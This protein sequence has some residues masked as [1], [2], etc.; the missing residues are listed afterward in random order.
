MRVGA[1]LS[2][3]R[4]GAPEN[5][6]YR[7]DNDLLPVSHP[8]STR[9]V[10]AAAV[11]DYAEELA[12]SLLGEDG[13]ASTEDAIFAL[14]EFSGLGYEAEPAVRAAWIRAVNSGQSPYQR[15]LSVA[16]YTYD[17]SDADLLPRPEK[18]AVS[19]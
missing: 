19:E 17:S 9:G 4:S 5:P 12:V 1:F 8:R 14:T 7:V 10:A 11:D 2:L 15:A 13:Y 6:A 18:G 3:L 16:E